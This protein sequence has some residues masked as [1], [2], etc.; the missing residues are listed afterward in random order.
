MLVGEEVYFYWFLV[1][2]IWKDRS[3]VIDQEVVFRRRNFN[4]EK[5]VD[6]NGSDFLSLYSVESVFY[7][8]Y[9]FTLFRLFFHTFYIYLNK[10]L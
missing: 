3:E 9:L 8:L 4:L 7:N 1:G 10:S 6:V 2:N 5:K